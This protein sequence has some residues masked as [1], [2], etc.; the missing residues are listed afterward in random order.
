MPKKKKLKVNKSVPVHIGCLIFP[1]NA[2]WK[3]P[4][5]NS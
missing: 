5:D 4:F 1:Q 2:Q 3:V